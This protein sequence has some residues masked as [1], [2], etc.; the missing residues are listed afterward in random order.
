MALPE[1]FFSKLICPACKRD[2]LQ[3]LPEPHRLTCTNCHTRFAVNDGIPVLL[4]DEAE[5]GE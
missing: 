4:T 3:E 5:T 1:H 2:A